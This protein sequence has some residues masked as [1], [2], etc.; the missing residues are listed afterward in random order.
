[1]KKPAK[2]P[3]R[4]HATA[5]IWVSVFGMAIGAGCYFLAGEQANGPTLPLMPPPL[6]SAGAVPLR[7]AVIPATAADAQY[8][9]AER[10]LLAGVIDGLAGQGVALISLDGQPAQ[11]FATGTQV[12]P[13]YVLHSVSAGRAMLAERTDLPV[14]LNLY[15]SVPKAATS[16][17]LTR[18]TTQVQQP[19]AISSAQLAGSSPALAD[20]SA[21]PPP[22]LDSRYRAAVSRRPIPH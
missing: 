16:D 3:C 5:A 7:P 15:L 4:R 13:G 10:F 12:A 6:A 17:A 1:M 2:T 19:L 8:K 18:I 20:A 22:R 9:S 14:K 11:P 21:G